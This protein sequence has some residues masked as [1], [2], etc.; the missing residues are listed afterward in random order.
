MRCSAASMEEL[1]VAGDRIS[2]HISISGPLTCKQSNFPIKINQ[3]TLQHESRYESQSKLSIHC[4]KDRE[5]S[6]ADLQD[7]FYS[8]LEHDHLQ[9]GKCLQKCSS[10]T[11]VRHYDHYI[12]NFDLGQAT[13][14]SNVLISIYAKYCSFKDSITVFNKVLNRNVIT[15]TAIITAYARKGQGKEAFVLYKRM[16]EEGVSPNN[17]TYISLLGACTTKESLVEGKKIHSRMHDD[18]LADVIVGTALVTMY[19][20]C[21]L[22]KDARAVFDRLPNGNIVSWNAMITVYVDHEQGRE[23]ISLFQLM[24]TLGLNANDCTYINSLRACAILEDVAQ[25]RAI[26]TGIVEDGLTSDLVVANAIIN[27]YG[28]CRM[29]AE[30]QCVF[31][32]MKE[33]DLVTWNGIITAYA[34]QGL[35]A[36]GLDTFRNM[37]QQGV[38]PDTVT[39][40][41]AISACASLAALEEGKWIHASLLTDG[42]ESDVQIGNA[43][44]H[45]YGKC[46]ALGSARSVFDKIRP[47]NVISWTAILA[48]FSQ[49]GHA[50][51]ALQLYKE[52]QEEHIK[53]DEVT[54]IILLSACSHAGLVEEGRSCFVSMEKDYHLTPRVEHYVCMIDLFGRAGMLAD[55]EQFI[56]KM[57]CWPDERLWSA[58][59][60]SCRI[61]SDTFRG[62]HAAEQMINLVPKDTSPYVLL[63]NLY[64]VNSRKNDSERIHA[65]IDK[66]VKVCKG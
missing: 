53:P 18:Q 56:R 39:F 24:Q 54:Y 21:G 35:G 50:K 15:W 23:A 65:V 26:H 44:I 57:P 30:A 52:M 19:G 17:V 55:A 40:I 63:S 47:R 14:L 62:K 33:H 34:Q 37:Q 16:Q 5:E 45:M 8:L 9:I 7:G 3:V 46:G 13:H 66:M 28:K 10:L 61:H 29:P 49:Q 27:M 42:L 6:L 22:V 51:V 1:E 25:G 20:R 58:L 60:A 32:Q 12:L 2:D 41:G 4:E 11:Q 38:K 64:A 48:A 43:L 36:Q 31:N 59:L